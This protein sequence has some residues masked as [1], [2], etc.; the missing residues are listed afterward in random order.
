MTTWYQDPIDP[1]PLPAPLRHQP[2]H[3]QPPP[4]PPPLRRH[5]LP[6]R[7]RI[8]HPWETPTSKLPWT[9]SPKPWPPSKRPP[10]P[11]RRPSRLTRRRS[12]PWPATSRR[13]RP[14]RT[15]TVSTTKTARPNT[16]GRNFRATTASPIRSPSSTSANRSSFNSGSCRRSV[17]GWPPTISRT[18]PPSGTSTSRKPRAR[19]R[20]SDSRNCSTSVS[21]HRCAPSPSSSSRRVAARGRWKITKTAF[22]P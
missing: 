22:R 14:A 16:G 17:L 2:H 12:R 11:L 6:P 19:R 13:D 10:R 3:Q 15:P 7:H 4:P 1:L 8:Q 20:G 9:P 5:R 18:A 21:G